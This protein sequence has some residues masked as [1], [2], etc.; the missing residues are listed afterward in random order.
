M[1]LSDKE[2]QD[3]LYYDVF[4]GD[5]GDPGDRCLENKVVIARK[6]HECFGCGNTIEIGSYNL[7]RKMVWADDKSFVSYRWCQNCCEKM[8]NEEYQCGLKTI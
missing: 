7:I 3:L 8:L 6:E 4:E 1:K 2:K 5:F